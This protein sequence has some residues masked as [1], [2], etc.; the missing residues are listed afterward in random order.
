MEEKKHS[1]QELSAHQRVDTARIAFDHARLEAIDALQEANREGFSNQ[2]LERLK[3]AHVAENL[4]IEE[5]M[6]AL[7]ALHELLSSGP[8]P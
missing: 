1:E 8:H 4:A 6:Q 3:A 5:Y 7:R 2:R